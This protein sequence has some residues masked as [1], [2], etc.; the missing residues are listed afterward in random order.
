MEN[1][2]TVVVLGGW[3]P[4]PL[5]A[6]KW[7]F[8]ERCIFVEPSIPMPPVGISCCSDPCF[9]LLILELAITPWLCSNLHTL[10][11]AFELK[12]ITWA[13]SMCSILVAA[14]LLARLCIAGLVRNAMRV[15]AQ[16]ASKIIRQRSVDIVVGFSWG[17]G[18]ASNLLEEGEV[19][20]EGKPGVMLLAPTTA[21]MA[22]CALRTDAASAIKID[23]IDRSRVHVFHATHDPFCPAS[24]RAR[25]EF[26]GATTYVLHDSHIF[27]EPASLDEIACAFHALCHRRV[28]DV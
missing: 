8:R 2:V 25:W 13:F 23:S 14:M 26:T 5:N 16:C 20:V 28:S 12:G 15:G 22:S 4:G 19:G 1:P 17:G 24:Q 9:V 11:P 3:S 10:S 18:I 21:A 27:G 7:R 6:L